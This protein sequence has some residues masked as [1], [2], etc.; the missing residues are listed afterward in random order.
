VVAAR[1]HIILA[2]LGIALPSVVLAEFIGLRRR[3][4]TALRLARRRSQAMGVP[5]EVGAVTGT[6]LPFE[7]GLLW[8]ELMRRYGRCWGSRSVWRECLCR[9]Q[10]CL[11]MFGGR[12]MGSR[13]GADFAVSPPVD[14]AE[15]G[16][17]GCGGAGVRCWAGG[18]G[19]SRNGGMRDSAGRDA[20][21]WSVVGLACRSG[22][23]RAAW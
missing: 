14:G 20:V 11:A 6:V 2:C 21:W 17:F 12:M 7:M 15:Q 18:R 22:D 16:P 1:F 3:D 5:I 13:V 4:E 8:P 9:G 19:S 23:G 10:G